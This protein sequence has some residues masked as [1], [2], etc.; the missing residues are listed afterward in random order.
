MLDHLIEEYGDQV[1]L[2]QQ[3]IQRLNEDITHRYNEI[4]RLESRIQEFKMLRDEFQKQFEE[5]V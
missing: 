3:Q 2:Q 5:K 4:K 1:A